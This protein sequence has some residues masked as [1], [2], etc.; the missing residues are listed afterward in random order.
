MLMAKPTV[1]PGTLLI[2]GAPKHFE[3]KLLYSKE[4]RTTKTTIPVQ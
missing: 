4:D 3:I 1:D 2:I